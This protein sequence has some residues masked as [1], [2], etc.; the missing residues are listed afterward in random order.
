M[1]N[2]GKLSAINAGSTLSLLLVGHFQLARD[3]PDRT[4]SR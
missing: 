2:C 1:Y 3:V 4:G